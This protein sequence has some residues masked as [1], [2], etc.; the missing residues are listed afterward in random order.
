MAAIELL[1]LILPFDLP[2]FRVVAFAAAGLILALPAAALIL[3]GTAWHG[4]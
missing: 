2:S 3:H 4:R 1:Q